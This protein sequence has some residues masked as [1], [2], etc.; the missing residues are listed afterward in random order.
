MPH[1]AILPRD[2]HWLRCALQVM[3]QDVGLPTGESDEV[4]SRCRPPLHSECCGASGAQEG[5]G[6]AKIRCICSKFTAHAMKLAPAA[7]I[8]R[9]RF[10]G[11]SVLLMPVDCGEFS[12]LI[13]WSDHQRALLSRV[14]SCRGCEVARS[15]PDSV[16]HSNLR[17]SVSAGQCSCA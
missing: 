16:D 12:K 3:L 15:L 9:G 4:P 8:R 6:K 17:Y 5:G 7:V 11:M 13:A 2:T 14:W 1:T 10:G